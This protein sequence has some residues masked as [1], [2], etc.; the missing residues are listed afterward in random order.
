MAL[1]FDFQPHPVN[2]SSP[3]IGCAYG[4]NA[5]TFCDVVLYETAAQVFEPK[6]PAY[7]DGVGS[8]G[9]PDCPE[10]WFICRL[11]PRLHDWQ[12]P[13]ADV[14]HAST[15]QGD[16]MDE[17]VIVKVAA[18]DQFQ[19]IDAIGEVVDSAGQEDNYS[20]YENDGYG[21]SG[22][23]GHSPIQIVATSVAK[24]KI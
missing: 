5:S 13:E 19:G 22:G 18:G 20:N 12:R 1:L 24:R 14:I 8:P 11:L 17:G 15:G 16:G 3:T 2:G 6:N 4:L 10:F 23:Y 9:V 21:E 7:R